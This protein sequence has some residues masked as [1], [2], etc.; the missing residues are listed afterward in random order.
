MG[1][2]TIRRLRGVS[3]LFVGL[4]ALVVA[5][6]VGVVPDAVERPLVVAGLL[7]VTAIVAF[8]QA[9]SLLRGRRSAGR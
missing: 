5:G 7:V 4:F 8:W 1:G 3:A 6:Y 2:T 9:N